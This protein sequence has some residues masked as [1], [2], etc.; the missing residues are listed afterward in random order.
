[1]DKIGI[2]RCGVIQMLSIKVPLIGGHR[3]YRNRSWHNIDI[4][5]QLSPFS[6]YFKSVLS[7]RY[8]C[9]SQWRRGSGL[10]C[11][12]GDPGSIPGIPSPLWAL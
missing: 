10:D 2:L 7:E 1:M 5:H 9:P 8:D 12:S 6:R 4:S 3:K 11:G